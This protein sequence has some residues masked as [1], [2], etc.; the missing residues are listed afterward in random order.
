M[1]FDPS[2]GPFYW[3]PRR[4]QEDDS[5]VIASQSTLERPSIK[6]INIAIAIDIAI[7]RNDTFYLIPRKVAS[8]CVDIENINI[9]IAVDI[10]SHGAL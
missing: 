8:Q 7:S 2:G 1:R 9:A 6:N 3:H 10:A 5:V 4:R